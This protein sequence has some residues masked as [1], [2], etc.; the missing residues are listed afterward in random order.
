MRNEEKATRFEI[1]LFIF[2]VLFSCMAL[3]SKHEAI[4]FLIQIPENKFKMQFLLFLL[5]FFLIVFVDIWFY[6]VIES[7]DLID[8]LQ[9]LTYIKLVRRPSMITFHD[10]HSMTNVSVNSDPEIVKK[11]K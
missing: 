8:D 4:I 1:V 5:F 10:S 9:Y 3:N 11:R 7:S 6:L 2:H